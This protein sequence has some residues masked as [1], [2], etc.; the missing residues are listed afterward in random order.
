MCPGSP[1]RNVEQILDVDKDMRHSFTDSELIAVSA[2]K[3][4]CDKEGIYYK[5]LFDL[6]KYVLVTHTMA[7]D[8]NPKAGD[9]RLKAS[10]KRLRK[11]DKW[12]E[13]NGIKSVDPH[14]ACLE[15]YNEF[16]DFLINH[17]AT[18]K[19]GRVVLATNWP[20]HPGDYALASKDNCAKYFAAD[21]FRFDLGAADMEE[22]RRGVCMVQ[23]CDGKMSVMSGYKYLRFLAKAKDLM[24]DM[25]SNRFKQIMFE[26]PPVVSKLVKM[27]KLLLP[28]KIA[29]RVNCVSSVAEMEP[30]LVRFNDA[31]MGQ[32]EW[33]QKRNQK[34]QETLENL[35]L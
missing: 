29:S 11:R 26:V 5:H 32:G 21:M 33:F 27:G 14:Q 1:A 8:S 28:P 18:D 10:L 35:S 6:A 17:Y 4:V 34:Y 20:N 15:I 22:A 12:M 3:E 31:D 7:D 24:Y 25:H 16:P 9:I 13:K 23:I 2:L 30:H 19:E